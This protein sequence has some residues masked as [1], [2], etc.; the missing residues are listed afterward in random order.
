MNRRV[1]LMIL[2]LVLCAGIMPAREAAADAVNQPEIVS[3]DYNV[4][5]TVLTVVLHVPLSVNIM[6]NPSRFII[7]TRI[8]RESEICR[9]TI[10]VPE[11][12]SAIENTGGVYKVTLTQPLISAPFNENDLP[13][14]GEALNVTA[15]VHVIDTNPESDPLS[16]PGVLTVKPVPLD[17]SMVVTL[18]QDTFV[19]TGSA[20]EPKVTVVTSFGRKLRENRDFTV[21]FRNNIDPGTATAVITGIR[22]YYGTLTKTFSITAKPDSGNSGSGKSAREPAEIRASDVSLTVSKKT[23]RFYLHAVTNGGKLS[24]SG[25]NKNIAVDGAGKVT[26]KK[27]Y[28]GKAVITITAAET[29][30]H[31]SSRKSITVTVNPPKT[32]ILSAKSPAPKKILIRWKKPAFKGIT[33][34]QIRL[35]L[36]KDFFSKVKTVTVKGYGKTSKAIAGLKRG[37]TYYV[38]VRTFK[39][40]G[41]RFCS[42][43]SKARKVRIR[44]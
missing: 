2:L 34:Y 44:K 38:Q 18:A 43:W 1:V 21:S 26:V 29:D 13:R 4:S 31:A 42:A 5:T 33:G 16:Q 11:G 24:Y 8:D 35:S 14:A 10:T 3:M 7:E 32:R 22:D 41:I 36:K 40:S 28:I 15:R 9:A 17:K 27:N 20:C 30:A 12:N 19:Y 37:K 39:K 6:D 23:R 25:S